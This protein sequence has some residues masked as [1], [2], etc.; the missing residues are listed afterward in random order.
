MIDDLKFR[1]AMGQ[2]ATGIT[3][4][5]TEYEKEVVAMTVNAFMS[6]SLQP[7]IVAVSIGEQASM[8]NILPKTKRFGVSILKKE[9][10]HKSDLFASVNEYGHQD[11]FIYKKD[12]PVLKNCLT[13]LVC[14]V[15][16]ATKV[17]DHVVYFG[18]VID[19]E[20]FNG[21]PILYYGS[22]YRLLQDE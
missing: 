7:K 18:E 11:M 22:Q 19:L 9:Q 14:H 15:I 13:H 5:S 10:Q 20:I 6:I 21:E 12:I 2:F 8:Y 17:G 3:V 1:Q 4:V 16:E